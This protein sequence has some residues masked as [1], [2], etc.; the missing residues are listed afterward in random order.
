MDIYKELEEKIVKE[1]EPHIG[2]V[3]ALSGGVDSSLLAYYIKPRYAISVKLPGDEK[4]NEI[5]WSEK[6]CKEL[7]I[8]QLIVECD[9]TKF[10]EYVETAVK[11]IGRPISHF[12]IFPLFCLYQK[13]HEI[14]ETELILGDGPDE[15]MCGYARDLIFN[16]LTQLYT[17]ESMEHY[18]P[19]IDILSSHAVSLLT[20]L[21]N[22]IDMVEANIAMR[23]DMDDMSDA[24]AKH[25]GIKNIRPY[26]DNKELDDYMKNLPMDQKIQGEYGKWA[27]RQILAQYLPEVADRKKKVGGPVYP[28]NQLKNWLLN[29]EFDK[30]EWIKY[31]QKF[32]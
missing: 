10:D 15:T 8:E 9:E 11:L 6:V 1:C 3:V 27:L 13:L 26:Q 22:H 29:G 7:G 4:Y 19:L 20:G 23:K 17:W 12:N 18:K 25:F 2:K 24:I 30:R 16:H 14:G 28:V 32:L 5:E 31:Q 21:E